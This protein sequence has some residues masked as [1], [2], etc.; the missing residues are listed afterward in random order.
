MYA[1]GE[2]Y[3]VALGRIRIS[4]REENSQFQRMSGLR[5]S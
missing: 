2:G 3:P 4:K 5:E 1:V